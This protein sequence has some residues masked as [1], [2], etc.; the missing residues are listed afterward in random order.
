[1]GCALSAH[2]EAPDPNRSLKC[3]THR[4][5]CFLVFWESEGFDGVG[6]ENK[7]SRISR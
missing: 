1:M 4:F 5:L 6:V 3:E 2:G 7:I